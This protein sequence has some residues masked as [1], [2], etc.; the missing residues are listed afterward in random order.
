LCQDDDGN[1]MLMDINAGRDSQVLG[2]VAA[3]IKYM[4]RD[5]AFMA[6]EYVSLVE[7]TEDGEFSTVDMWRSSLSALEWM[8][9][10]PSANTPR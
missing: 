2:P 5:D 4:D 1:D 10:S 9:R 7:W 8:I 3:V 6:G